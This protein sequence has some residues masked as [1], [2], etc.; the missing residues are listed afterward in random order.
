MTKLKKYPLLISMIVSSVLIVV[1]LIILGFFGIKLNSTLIGG[2]RFE[3]SFSSETDTVYYANELKKI[4]SSHGQSVDSVFV[5]DKFT[6]TS[7]ETK[8]T[9]ISIVV[10][11]S[12]TDIPE[13]T[14]ESI[15][16]DIVKKLEINR[17]QI[18][19]IE[20]V[21]SSIEA[22]SVLFLGIAIGIIAILL[23]V[24][25]WI[26]YNVLTGFT[27][28]IAVLHNI[29]LYLAV[30]IL[31]RVELGLMSL[32][33]ALV[34]TVIMCMAIISI[35]ERYRE[36]VKL[37]LA[38]KMT[39]QERMMQSEMQVLK[40]YLF[41]V[42][43]VVL[44]IFLNLFIP[45]STVRFTSLNIF[46]ALLV[47]IYTTV[48]VAPAVCAN[49]LEIKEFRLKSILS[50]NNNVSSDVKKKSNKNKKSKNKSERKP[51]SEF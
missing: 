43:A 44:I 10:N 11:I 9:T 14:K 12:G 51:L 17:T 37:H 48:L 22:K 16:N 30:L 39:V 47:T 23:F 40:P 38:E 41:V 2:S 6:S 24:F 36:E 46:F 7:E 27:F 49:F 3:V 50:R 1:S 34:L 21:T 35:F 4:V 13:E 8:F 15:I 28:I 5:E 42:V 29:I 26:R 25:G 19:D 18:S 31:T 32:S 33:V 20:E 45:A